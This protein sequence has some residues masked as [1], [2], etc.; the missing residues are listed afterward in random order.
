MG[1]DLRGVAR[2][3]HE[4]EG[5][6]KLTVVLDSVFKVVSDTLRVST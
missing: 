5:T 1:S 4:F 6:V 2:T 3:E